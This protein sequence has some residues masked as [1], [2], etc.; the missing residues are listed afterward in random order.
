MAFGIKKKDEESGKKDKETTV[1]REIEHE[2]KVYTVEDVKNLLAGQKSATEKS[3]SVAG[4][5]A[6]AQRYGVDVETYLSQAE[7]AFG[8]MNQLI[9]K[10]VI[11]RKG[12]VLQKKE[13]EKRASAG[14]GDDLSRLFNEQN[15]QGQGGGGSAMDEGK[16]AEI[17]AKALGPLTEGMKTLGARVESVDKTQGD[18][19]R[20]DLQKRIRK[21]HENLSEDD[22]SRVFGFAMKD[23]TKSLWDHAKEFSA[24]KT[25]ETTKLRGEHAKEFGVN[26][27]TFD[28]NKL[29]QQS[30]D[31]G[32]GAMFKEKKFSFDKKD[33]KTLSPLEAAKSFVDSQVAAD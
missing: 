29:N 5:V 18:L 31:G 7:G 14:Q 28:Q 1:V 23:D 3:Q 2:G 16:I 12:G 22:V 6:A 25:E 13:E 26:L 19:I 32:A 9:E 21:E 27:E 17:V 8:V 30:A 15:Q 10:G 4:I 20:L 24:K 11:D 33:D